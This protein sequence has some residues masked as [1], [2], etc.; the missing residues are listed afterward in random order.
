[1]VPCGVVHKPVTLAVGLGVACNPAAPVEAPV[2]GEPSPAAPREAE[3][4]PPAAAA[5]TDDAKQPEGFAAVVRV[6]AK[7]GGKKFQGVWLERDDGERWVV[8]YRAEPWL[9]AFEGRRVDVTGAVY[10]PTG[11][12]ILATHFRIETLRLAGPESD[13]EFVA[14]LAELR[15]SGTFKERVGESGTKLE[16]ERYRVF[17]ADDGA[18]YLLANYPERGE[19]GVAATVRARVVELSPYTAHR[20][21]TYLWVLDVRPLQ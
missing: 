3:A 5:P 1:M 20:G 2:S 9:V 19:P 21:G 15:L 8:A 7:P 11:Q 12:A 17:E 16:G 13:A 18:V 14:A 6:D 4:K 10:Q